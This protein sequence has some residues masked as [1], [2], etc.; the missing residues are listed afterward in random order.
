MLLVIVFELGFRLCGSR[1]PCPLLLVLFHELIEVHDDDLFIISALGIGF[2]R[3]ADFHVLRELPETDAVVVGGHKDL[4]T[5]KPPQIGNGRPMCTEDH[6]NPSLLSVP[7]SDEAFAMTGDDHFMFVEVHNL[8]DVRRWATLQKANLF[9]HEHIS[10]VLDG[11]QAQHAIFASGE[12]IALFVEIVKRANG[13][14]VPRESHALRELSSLTDFD[15]QD[16]FL[17]SCSKKPSVG[18]IH[19]ECVE[20]PSGFQLGYY[21]CFS[22]VSNL[23]LL[24]NTSSVHSPGFQV[25]PHAQNSTSVHRLDLESEFERL[26]G[27]DIH[28]VS[29]DVA[30]LQSGVE[31]GRRRL[32]GDLG[33]WAVIELSAK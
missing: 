10:W 2:G 4:R 1:P 5:F 16:L 29:S 11:P 6:H 14:G 28:T 15:D 3:A 9:G 8:R 22:E 21:F 20:P 23:D 7:H 13:A 32:P 27:C 19:R 24:V 33:D 30:I 25:D 18:P 26:F 17:R 12:Q 31:N